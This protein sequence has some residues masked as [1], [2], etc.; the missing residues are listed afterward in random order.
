MQIQSTG[1]I[2]PPCS[3]IEGENFWQSVAIRNVKALHWMCLF[4]KEKFNF[5]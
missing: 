2:H 5:K 4:F 3:I 1:F